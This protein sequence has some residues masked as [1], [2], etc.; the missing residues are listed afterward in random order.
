VEEKTQIT[1]SVIGFGRS[2]T[3]LTMRLLQQLGVAIG[4]ERDLL[5]P[6]QSDN[7]R[8]Y[9]EPRWMVDLN[10]EILAALGSTWWQPL[11]VAQGWE[12]DTALD[13]LRE[14]AKDLVA[15]K[16]GDEP[17]RG[18]KDPR[19]TL[20]LPL[21]KQVVPDQRYVICLRNPI[22]AIASIQRRPEPTQSVAEW[23]ELWL[24]YTARAL[25]ETAGAPRLIVFYDDYFADAAREVERLARF[26]GVSPADE[27]CALTTA[28][29]ETDLRHHVTS[30]L[31]LASLD[32]V[33]PSARLLYLA[34]LA[35]QELRRGTNDQTSAIPAAVEQLATSLWTTSR[36]STEAVHAEVRSQLEQVEAHARGL[37]QQVALASELSAERALAREQSDLL[38]EAREQELTRLQEELAK[39][40]HDVAELE[41][42]IAEL[43][44][45]VSWRVTRPAR[46]GKRLLAERGRR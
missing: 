29:V 27:R 6:Q 8:G 2:G 42:A 20:T 37:E 22:D 43:Q 39:Q 11:S 31:E 18:W 19:L 25:Q 30:A 12:R 38:L 3:S 40:A 17:L 10:D 26:V 24:E 1:V 7:P 46:V 4:A 41:R 16:L 9:F 5:E 45:T 14:R 28:T 13:P 35:T 32:A 21:W 34:L 44:N 33:A 36:R 15:E 23:S